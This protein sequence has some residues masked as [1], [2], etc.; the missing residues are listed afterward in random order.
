[1]RPAAACLLAA[2]CLAAAGCGNDAPAPPAQQPPPELTL[3]QAIGQRFVFPFAGTTI[4]QALERRIRK[5]EAAGVILF[6]RNVRSVEQVRALTRRLQRIP[7]PRA[8]DHPLLVLVDHEGGPVRRLPGPPNRAAADVRTTASARAAGSAAG[9]LLRRA[10]V[11]VD[12]APVADV[13]RAGS[14]MRRERRAFPGDARQVSRLAAAFAD[15]LRAAGVQPAYKH[16]PGFGAAKVNT[17]DAPARI[18]TSLATLRR[19]D[20]RPYREADDVPVVMLSTA[21]YP[22]RDPRPA[23]FSRRWVAD[24]LR[25]RLRLPDAVAITDDL[26]T[27]AVKSF[28]TPAQLAFFAVQAGVDIP[29]FAKDYRT[30]A[31]AAEGL[32]AAVRRGALTK[33]ALDEGAH[34]VLALRDQLDSPRNTQPL[35]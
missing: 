10:G 35:R 15:G 22:A 19:V 28:G 7:R 13:G 31:R 21:I 6:G 27:P 24:E 29:L 16:F 23:A 20:L 33:A 1:M 3:R 2:A 14:A 5:G 17:D 18:T 9:R 11:N 26:Q 30:A 12:L 4:P 8:L 34:R 25:R 32:Q